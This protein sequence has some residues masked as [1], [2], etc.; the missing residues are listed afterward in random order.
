MPCL[1]SFVGMLFPPII[2][3]GPERD[4][5]LGTLLYDCRPDAI[6]AP[7]GRPPAGGRFPPR[8]DISLEAM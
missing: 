1:G 7:E 6:L 8:V 4:A 5:E 3:L 2:L